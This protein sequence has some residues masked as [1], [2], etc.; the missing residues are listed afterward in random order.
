MTDGVTTLGEDMKLETTGETL[1]TRSPSRTIRVLNFPKILP[2]PVEA[3]STFEED[4][5]NRAVLYRRVN[6]LIS[7][8]FVLPV[9]PN[10]YTPDFYATTDTGKRFV[11]EVKV[12]RKVQGYAELFDKA[13]DYL[14]P[15]GIAFLV[16]TEKNLRRDRINKRAL[17]ILRYL[18][19]QY[20]ESTCAA[21]VAEVGSSHCGVTIGQLIKRGVARELIFHLMAIRKLTTGPKLML[22]DSA[23]VFVPNRMERDDED[24]FT[25][26]VGVA[27]WGKDV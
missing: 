13:A 1:L 16:V 24:C 2:Q 26:W 22:D 10:G 17:R 20:L 8:P 12:A 5:I 9:S 15:K 6:K 3:E 27:P 7:Q 14:R 19:A 4:L 21:A 11:I 23:L 25:R 18:K